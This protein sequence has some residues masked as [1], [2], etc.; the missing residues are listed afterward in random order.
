MARPRVPYRPRDGGTPLGVFTM[1]VRPEHRWLLLTALIVGALLLLSALAMNRPNVVWADA[2]PHCPGCRH[3]VKP[4]ANRCSDCRFE[5]D[6]VVADEEDSPVSPF[7]LSADEQRAFKA[8]VEA[9]GEEKAA[10]RVA[11]ATGLSATDAARYLDRLTRSSCGYCAGTGAHLGGSGDCPVC[12]GH[13]TC[14]SVDDEDTLRIRLGDEDAARDL[15]RLKLTLQGLGRPA[16][17]DAGASARAEIRELL[18]DYMDD[19]AGSIE[20]TQVPVPGA[21]LGDESAGIQS[22]TGA[23][24]RSRIV[25]V[26]KALQAE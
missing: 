2:K 12:F 11:T 18:E 1:G 3:E 7:I 21:L 13:D 25:R 17:G 4:Y 16:K 5:F 10:K 15:R 9:L 6:W 24:A 22:T 19:H 26:L 23:L 8:A 14:V 20:A